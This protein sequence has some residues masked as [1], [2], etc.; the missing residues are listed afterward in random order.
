MDGNP[1]ASTR[2]SCNPW[3]PCTN[4]CVW[5]GDCNAKLSTNLFDKEII[6]LKNQARLDEEQRVNGLYNNYNSF[7]EPALFPKMAIGCCQQL[8]FDG[9]SANDITFSNVTNNCTINK[10]DNTQSG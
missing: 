10:Q 5:Y 9:I 4:G 8:I 7:V 3:F 6:K 2:S 1:E